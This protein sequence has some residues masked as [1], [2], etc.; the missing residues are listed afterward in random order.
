[1]KDAR[2]DSLLVRR[3][4]YPR[5]RP[6]S[7]FRY[8]VTHVGLYCVNVATFLLVE[9]WSLFV[10]DSNWRVSAVE[11]SAW[12]LVVTPVMLMFWEARVDQLGR[13]LL[14]V[15]GYAERDLQ[16]DIVDSIARVDRWRWLLVGLPIIMIAPTPWFS[17]TLSEKMHLEHVAGH[18]AAAAVLALGGVMAGYAV[19]A[20][21][22]TI[23]VARSITRREIEQEWTLLGGPTAPT[24]ALLEQFCSRSALYFSAGAA[25]LAP[26]LLAGVRNSNGRTSVLMISVLALMLAVALVLLI[27][28]AKMLNSR[29][30]LHRDRYLAQLGVAIEEITGEL[31]DSDAPID[32]EHYFKLRSLLEVRQHVLSQ[33]VSVASIDLL[34]RIPVT[35]MPILSTSA[36]WLA[37]VRPG[38]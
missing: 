5:L 14:E 9:V 22:S 21:A 36:A 17:P 30:R 38:N 34:R 24:S 25:V 16:I 37:L 19:W 32:A 2:S 4:P 11:V 26:G 28:P 6:G 27:W 13:Q 15:P 31:F 35:A 7:R 12:F 1:M 33:P 18:V 10:A 8:S 29:A 23:A 3:T 20:A